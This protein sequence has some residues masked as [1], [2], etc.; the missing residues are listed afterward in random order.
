MS[1]RN[2]PRTIFGWVM[3]DWAN[4]AYAT[5]AVAA[6]LPTYFASTIVPE[7]GVEILGRSYDAQTLWGYLIAAGT[8]LLFLVAPI[9]GAIA[10]ATASK[11]RFLAV[12]AYSG[13]GTAVLFLFVEAGDVVLTMGLLLLTQIGFVAAEVFANSMLPDITS[14]ETIDRVSAR[15]FS[16]GYIGGGLH[17]LLAAILVATHDAFG[18]TEETA[19]R[20][21]IA[22]SGLWWLGFTVFSVRRL[23]EIGTR[24]VARFSVVDAL[25][26]VWATGRRLPESPHLLLFLA[27]YFLYH[28]GIISVLALAAVFATDTLELTVTEVAIAILIVQ[29]VGAV[30]T[31]FFGRLANRVGA[32]RAILISLGGW[33]VAVAAGLGLPVGQAF[34]LY[35]LAVVLGLVIG[36]TSALSRSLFATTIPADSAAEFF[37]LYAV[38][39]R[40]SAIWGPL[41]FALVTDLTGSSRAGLFSLVFF[42][43]AGGLL[44]ALVD[45]DRARS[46]AA[47]G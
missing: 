45:V 14:R 7:G 26:R 21:G 31:F 46:W 47:A 34:P 28:D 9:W 25:R 12:A 43:L 6:L 3:Y 22:S 8:F 16:Y 30:G 20:I 19:I 13:A 2:D 18:L 39:G 24:S 41:L 11:R 36:G 27:A 29:F 1:I 42:F 40:F 5:T 33:I 35:G 44:L 10:D 32:K 23:P 15:G 38:M 17:F 4:S 37:G